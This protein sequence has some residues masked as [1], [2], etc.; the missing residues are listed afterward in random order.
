VIGADVDNLKKLINWATNQRTAQSANGLT[1]NSITAQIG[2]DVQE[3]NLSWDTGIVD[4]NGSPLPP[5]WRI[6]I[7]A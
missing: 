6:S 3:V 5:D 4:G 7:P 2:L 1:I